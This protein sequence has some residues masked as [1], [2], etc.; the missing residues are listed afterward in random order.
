MEPA[1][2]ADEL[3]RQPSLTELE[4]EQRFSTEA[5]CIEY[6]RC[7]RWPGGFR[8]R[9]AAALAPGSADPSTGRVREL[10][11]RAA[12]RQWTCPA[13]TGSS[14]RRLDLAAQAAQL[15]GAVRPRPAQRS[16]EVDETYLGGED[17]DAHKGRSLT[18]H[19]TPVA[20]AVE[21]EAKRW[22]AS[23]SSPCSTRPRFRSAASSGRT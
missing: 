23:A 2:C 17:D 8:C 18:G 4:F 5:A 22:A 6:L 12:A 16:V 9:D 3:V 13:S 10:Q 21:G 11:P 1:E 7:Q 14:T 19:K 20:A 15:H